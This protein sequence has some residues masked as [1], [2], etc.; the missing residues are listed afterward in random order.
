MT[1]FASAGNNVGETSNKCLAVNLAARQSVSC[2]GFDRC[3]MSIPCFSFLLCPDVYLVLH[4][5]FCCLNQRTLVSLSLT[6]HSESQ[7][8]FT[9]DILACHCMKSTMRTTKALFNAAITVIS[10]SVY[11]EK[12][13]IQLSETPR[14]ICNH[15]DRDRVPNKRTINRFRNVSEKLQCPAVLGIT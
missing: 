3:L 10:N 1:A 13:C 7:I 12:K 5:L 4:M 8:I 11:C 14:D 15:P 6:N 9:A 2:Y